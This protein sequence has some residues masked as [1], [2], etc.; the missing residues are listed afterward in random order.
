MSRANPA[1]H[2]PAA[3]VLDRTPAVRLDRDRAF[4]HARRHSRRVRILRWALPSA[5]FTSFVLIALVVWLDPLRIYRGL[6]VDFG[7]ISITD[8]KLTIDAPKLSG[9]TQDRRPYS[10]TADS[11]AQDL[12][13]PNIIELNGIFGQVALANR[14]ETELRA[15]RGVYDLKAGDLQLSGGIEIEA[16]GGYQVKLHDAHVEVKKGRIVTPNPVYA[17]FP[18]GSLEAQRLEILGHGDRV[19]FDNVRMTLRLSPPED[20]Q[21][22]EASQ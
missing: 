18:D 8:N 4:R 9:F 17:I 16:T 20:N 15:K 6:P 10:L 13:Q 11:A 3:A 19:R 12:S 22:A 5:V 14:G 21:A 1:D 2:H 7:R